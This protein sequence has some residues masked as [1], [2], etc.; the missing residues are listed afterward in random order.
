MIRAAFFPMP[1]A[2]CLLDII[3]NNFMEPVE[4]EKRQAQQGDDSP[5]SNYGAS[6]QLL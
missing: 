3:G 6:K 5:F 4:A 1:D 2:L